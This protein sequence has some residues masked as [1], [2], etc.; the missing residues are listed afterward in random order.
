MAGKNYGGSLESYRWDNDKW[1]PR[2]GRSIR[3]N[4]PHL[5][6]VSCMLLARAGENWTKYGLE[7]DW[8]ELWAYVPP[9][10]VNALGRAFRPWPWPGPFSIRFWVDDDPA[11][12]AM[13][14]GLL[15]RK[16]YPW[17]FWKTS[18]FGTR[19]IREARRRG[20]LK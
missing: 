9:D 19:L 11:R 8:A 10:C 15:D 2:P 5:H 20:W 14:A 17:P 16:K 3:Y 4:L 1:P 6:V 18:K 13:Q 12:W 7:P